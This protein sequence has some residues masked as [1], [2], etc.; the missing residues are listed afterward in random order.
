MSPKSNTPRLKMTETDLAKH[1]GI[2]RSTVSRALHGTGRIS[3]ETRARVLAAADELG[4]V[5]NTLASDLAAGRSNTIGL[6]L[7]D[8]INP[9]YGALF[10][11]L[12]LSAAAQNLDIVSVTVSNDPDGLQQLSGLRRLLGLRV[13]GLLVATGGITSDQLRPF[14]HEVPTLR[15][16]RPETDPGINAVSYD[17]VRNGQLLAEHILGQGHQRI[18]VIHT[19]HDV[20]YPEWVR[21]TTMITRITDTGATPLVFPAR[22]RLDGITEALNAVE[23]DNVTA[24]MC[25][26]DRRQLDVM[27]QAQIRG[28]R[29][30]E[31]VSIT[32]CDGLLP[33]GDLLGLTTLR[34]PVAEL[35]KMA[36]QR[37]VELTNETPFTVKHTAI[38]GVLVPGST[39]RNIT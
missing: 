37:M 3:Q 19:D 32:G 16:G 15:V 28:I 26:T 7:R 31:A 5:R 10:S 33:G 11:N 39:S 14:L 36:I 29:Y 38:P 30:P 25:P 8:S 9:A 12:Q 24:V 18:A 34:L 13:A 27:R 21:S 22:D 20:S 17:E 1:L 2:S 35:G 4:F 6:L 23:H